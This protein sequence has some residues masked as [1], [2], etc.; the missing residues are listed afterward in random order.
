MANNNADHDYEADLETLKL[1]S[2]R[3][4]KKGLDMLNNMIEEVEERKRRA[5]KEEAERVVQ[6]MEDFNDIIP[7]S[8]RT[9]IERVEPTIFKEHEIRNDQIEDRY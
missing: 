4:P 8:Q 5:N 7:T 1:I 2:L 3:N 9:E 6:I